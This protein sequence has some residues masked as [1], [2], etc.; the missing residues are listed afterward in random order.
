MSIDPP[1]SPRKVAQ[2]RD[3]ASGSKDIKGE[4]LRMTKSYRKKNNLHCSSCSDYRPKAK[5]A[6]EVVEV[7]HTPDPISSSYAQPHYTV[8]GVIRAPS[9]YS[10]VAMMS[11]VSF[12][13]SSDNSGR[14]AWSISCTVTLSIALGARDRRT[15]IMG[16]RAVGRSHSPQFALDCISEA[17]TKSSDHV[18]LAIRMRMMNAMAAL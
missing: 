13:A 18:R 5:R 8:G 15:V 14:Q 3:F 2:C 11:A 1:A 17:F 6:A 10:A 9:L 12:T 7:D 16:L 4:T